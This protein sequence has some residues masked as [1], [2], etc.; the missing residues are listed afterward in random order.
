VVVGWTQLFSMV[1][2]PSDKNNGRV[3]R[4]CEMTLPAA[5]FSLPV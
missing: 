3:I 2:L 1:M 4:F 5:G